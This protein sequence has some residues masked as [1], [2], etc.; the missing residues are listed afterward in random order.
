MPY[1]VDIDPRKSLR[2]TRREYDVSIDFDHASKAWRQNK[3]KNG[4]S[5]RYCCGRLRK[6]GKRCM[7]RGE[8]PCRHH[9]EKVNTVNDI[10]RKQQKDNDR[11]EDDLHGEVLAKENA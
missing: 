8:G 3:V 5:Y 1:E 2:V 10:P 6:D 11:S 4:S 9:K 7:M